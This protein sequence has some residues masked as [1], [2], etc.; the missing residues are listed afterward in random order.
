MQLQSRYTSSAYAIHDSQSTSVGSRGYFRRGMGISFGT[1][2]ST[3][4]DDVMDAIDARMACRLSMAWYSHSDNVNDTKRAHVA[5]REA[6]LKGEGERTTQTEEER[7]WSLLT[8]LLGTQSG[9]P[10]LTMPASTIT[11]ITIGSLELNTY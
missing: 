9:V 10:S 6:E 2:G 1:A 4:L 8:S 7:M 3:E 5:I 11:P